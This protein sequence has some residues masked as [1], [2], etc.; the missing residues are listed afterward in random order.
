[1]LDRTLTLP[2]DPE[3]L[4]SFTARLLAEVKAAMRATGVTMA[5]AEMIRLNTDT[6]LED[7]TPFLDRIADLGARHVLIAVDDTDMARVQ[8]NYTGLCE[9]LGGYRL[10]A[11]LEFMPWTGVKDLATA[12]RIVEKAD[13]PA[14]AIVEQRVAGHDRPFAQ[15]AARGE[16]ENQ[17]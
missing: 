15:P 2:E 14:A 4:R 8:D 1:M 7:F 12:R 13:H 3:E 11:D 17:R 16:N 6:R 10:T 9:K 5:D